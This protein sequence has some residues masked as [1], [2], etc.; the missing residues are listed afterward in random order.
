MLETVLNCYQSLLHAI[1]A[2]FLKP[3]MH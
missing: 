2:W 1:T 3:C